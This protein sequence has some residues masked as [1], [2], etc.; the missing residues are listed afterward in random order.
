MKNINLLKDTKKAEEEMN[1]KGTGAGGF[2]LSAPERYQFVEKEGKAKSGMSSWFQRMFTGSKKKEKKEKSATPATEPASGAT[3]PIN[4]VRSQQ[5]VGAAPATTPPA[6]FQPGRRVINATP[7]PTRPAQPRFSAPLTSQQPPAPLPRSF[8]GSNSV[9][10]PPPPPPRAPL[11]PQ[12]RRAP[13]SSPVSFDVN[14]LPE[15][16]VGQY[17]PRK[18]LINL[19]VISG[20]TIVGLA[21]IYV[22]MI[23]YQSSI[24]TRTNEVRTEAGTVSQE[25]SSYQKQRTAALALKDKVD[26]IGERLDQHIYWTKF[27]TLLEKHT[28]PDVY[29]SNV[30]AAD[31]N[32]TLTLDA[33]GKDFSSVARQ[34]LAFQEATDFVDTVVINSAT[35]QTGTELTSEGVKFSID[36]KLAE[37]VFT[38]TAEELSQ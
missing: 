27:F 28:V 14:L 21:A 6:P 20:L 2:D 10:P 31:I 23:F 19:A 18:K 34:L 1:G 22:I 16:L 13:Q 29:F 24:V 35:R 4:Y 36:I 7:E 37:G 3:A 30:F 33:T 15:D 17:E 26:A 32:G 12:S 38:K 11:P 9:T 25:I 5:A 8:N